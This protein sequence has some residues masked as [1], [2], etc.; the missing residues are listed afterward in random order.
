MPETAPANT[1]TADAGVPIADA[2]VDSTSAD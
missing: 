2:P 1:G